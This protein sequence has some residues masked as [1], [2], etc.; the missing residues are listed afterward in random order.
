MRCF[1]RAPSA[2]TQPLLGARPSC[3]IRDVWQRGAGEL[4][5]FYYDYYNDYSVPRPK[6][7]RE[8]R[9]LPAPGPPSW[10]S[11]A[12]VPLPSGLRPRPPRA[13][14]SSRQGPA[15]CGA[16]A[17]IGAEERRGGRCRSRAASRTGCAGPG[18]SGPD[19]GELA[20]PPSRRARLSP[21]PPRVPPALL[22]PF[23][24]SFPPLFPAPPSGGRRMLAGLE[25]REEE[26]EEDNFPG[27]GGD[28][29]AG[30]PRRG[31]D[32]AAPAP[33]E[34]P[35]REGGG[36]EGGGSRE[37][38]LFSSAAAFEPGFAQQPQPEV[39]PGLGAR[40]EG[41]RGGREGEKERGSRA[42]PP[43]L[44]PPLPPAARFSHLRRTPPGSHPLPLSALF[45]FHF[46]MPRN[47][48]KCGPF[49]VIRQTRR[50]VPPARR[51]PSLPPFCLSLPLSPSLPGAD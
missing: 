39:R 36:A 20:V 38:P 31:M 10:V 50:H 30:T 27:R 6:A 37:R 40:R 5:L 17:G 28:S 26:E 2:G 14:I 46:C 29:G 9:L 12:C 19:G 25:V 7:R 48:L 22:P 4:F 32:G 45:L 11:A 51:A 44:P 8:L 13:P 16:G 21:S 47:L 18:V 23:V 24:P 42:P 15:Q 49:P 34:P 3:R 43:P 1:S 41:G 35:P 33:A